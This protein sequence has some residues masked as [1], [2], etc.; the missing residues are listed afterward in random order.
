M[1]QLLLMVILS[2]FIMVSI[3]K[4][5]TYV[6]QNG[7]V[8]QQTAD[9]KIVKIANTIPVVTNLATYI[10]GPVSAA[11]F[12]QQDI[13]YGWKATSVTD[14]PHLGLKIYGS[15]FPTYAIGDT[16]LNSL[17]CFTNDST[18]IQKAGFVYLADSAAAISR[19]GISTP[20]PYYFIKIKN[21]RTNAADVKWELKLYFRKRS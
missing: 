14:K 12:A 10:Y 21:A 11:N 8:E 7:Q 9:C 15:Y 20:Y 4:A 6:N 5:D 3:T 16:A 17:T 1:R 19:P 2:M 18:E 13:F